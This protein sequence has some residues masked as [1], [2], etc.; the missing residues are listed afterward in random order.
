MNK[1]TNPADPLDPTGS[2]T[3]IEPPRW[4]DRLLTWFVAPHLL[5]YVQGDLHE[6]FHKQVPQMGMVR[7]RRA[8]VRSA[9]HCL[10]PFFHKPLRHGTSRTNEYP[11]PTNLVM[12]TNYVKIAWR[13]LRK[14]QGF[15]FINIFG[16]AV[17][18]ACCMLIMLY[19]LDEL[20]FDR[21]NAKADRI[22]R[23]QS[24]IKFGGN[25]MHFAVA[26]DPMGPTLKKDYPQVEQFV[27]LHQRGT[28]LVKRAGETTNLREDNITF[29]DSTLFDVFTLPLISGDP[30]RAL[31]EPNTVVISESAAKRHF[32]DQNPMGQPMVFENN[33]T[34]RVS[35]VMRDM[36]RNSHF[37]SDF[38]VSMLN[39]DYPWGQW[40]SNNHHTYI[41][42]KP[43]R[44]GAPAD[45]VAFAKNFDSVIDKYV[46]HKRCQSSAQLWTSFGKRGIK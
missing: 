33:K 21:Y 29:A 17:G 28:W 35:G 8:Y 37:H 20:S 38:F 3:Q 15:T 25:D 7:A 23:V 31:A 12:L 40:L 39:D 1:P 46:G 14:Q 36:P 16:L 9:L 32:G 44:S 43:G 41:L 42:L 6:V 30:K 13:T 11:N 45:P 5:E 4:A 26:P 18:L 34:F 19:V 24:D 2:P 10:T 27:R 22:Y